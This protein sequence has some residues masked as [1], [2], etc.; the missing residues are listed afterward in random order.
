[1]TTAA[2][3]EASNPTHPAEQTA[4]PAHTPCSPRTLFKGAA[5]TVGVNSG[6]ALMLWWANT[7][8]LDEQMVYSQAIGLSIWALIN[9]GAQWLGRQGDPGGFPTGW[10]MALL[11]PS[12]VLLGAAIGTTLGNLYADHPGLLLNANPRM[13]WMLLVMTLVVGSAM[14]LYFYLV[15]KSNYLQSEL[16]R[17]QRQTTEAQLALLQSQLEPHMLFNTLANLRA[18]IGLDADKAQAMLDHLIAYLRATLSASRNTTGVHP[19]STEFERLADY[20]ALMSV[21]MGPRLS[22]TL[23]LPDAL[24]DVPVPPLLL[25]PLVENAIRHGLEP[26]VAGGQITVSARLDGPWLTL[27]VRDTGVGLAPGDPHHGFGLT[28]VRE[29]LRTQYGPNGILKLVANFP[30]GTCAEATFSIKTP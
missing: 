7:G 30:R 8:P 1:M 5:I 18:L 6:I 2:P 11:V 16:E 13:A 20:L 19:L 21:R 17:T 3:S 26:Q 29:R 10:R 9:A 14:T 25:Q 24:R 22:T 28:Q 15:G 4:H 27:T 23:D 12:G